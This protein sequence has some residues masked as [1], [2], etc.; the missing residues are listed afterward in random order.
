MHWRRCSTPTDNDPAIVKRRGV[1]CGT[2]L[3]SLRRHSAWRCRQSSSGSRNE[4]SDA[5]IQKNTAGF[6][7]SAATRTVC[8]VSELLPH[9]GSD[10]TGSKRVK[11]S[12]IQQAVS[13]LRDCATIRR[14]NAIRSRRPDRAPCRWD[15]F[16]PRLR[17]R[18]PQRGEVLRPI[19]RQLAVGRA[20][21]HGPAPD[22]CV[23][24]SAATKH[25]HASSL[26]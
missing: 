19:G 18:H 1:P 21:G 11:V 20:E 17:E 24:S 13:G 4:T 7:S 12:F 10:G 25:S 6:R 9:A 8:G 3:R 22:R 26:Q 2:P 15:W 5:P 23:E 14:S 16:P